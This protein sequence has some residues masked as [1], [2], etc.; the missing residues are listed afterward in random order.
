MISSGNADNVFTRYGYNNWKS[1]TEKNKG[2]RKHEASASHKEAVARYISTPA[3]VIGDVGELLCNQHAEEKMKSRK[4]LLAILGNIRYLAR[5][6]LPLRGNWNL[7][8]GSEENSNFYQ[9]LK[10][11]AEENSEILDW[12]RRKDDKYTSPV[13]Q[14][15]ILEAIALCMLRKI[16]ENIQ[17]AT[18]FTI[19]ADET[20]DISNKEQLVVCI[21]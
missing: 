16:S 13:I 8:T 11:R 1:A 18:F 9:L 20:A 15:E 12:L 6:A 4:V 17:N 10:L 21:R 14:N 2:F 19:M 7:E 5:Q 3:E